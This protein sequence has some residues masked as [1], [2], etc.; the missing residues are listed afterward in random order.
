[1]AAAG[2]LSAGLTFGIGKVFSRHAS[3]KITDVI[4]DPGPHWT[5][6]NETVDPVRTVPGARDV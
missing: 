6:A 3:K 5:R 4:D 1:M 2:V